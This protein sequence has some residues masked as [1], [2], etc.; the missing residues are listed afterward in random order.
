MENV[1]GK[2]I[3]LKQTTVKIPGKR[4][5]IA[6]TQGNFTTWSVNNFKWSIL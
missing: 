2:Q 1:R 6:P 3:L 4:P 5:P